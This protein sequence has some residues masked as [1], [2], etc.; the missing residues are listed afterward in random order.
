MLKRKSRSNQLYQRSP[1]AGYRRRLRQV[2]IHA[3]AR[4]LEANPQW[5][6][7]FFDLRF[8]L[9]RGLPIIEGHLAGVP[10]NSAIASPWH[11]QRSGLR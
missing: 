1:I 3:A 5:W 6:E 2:L 7:F 11:G 8:L 4:F 9:N 10:A